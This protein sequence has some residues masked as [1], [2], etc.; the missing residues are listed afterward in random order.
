[1]TYLSDSESKGNYVP[2]RK[3]PKQSINMSLA[4]QAKLMN[5]TLKKNKS[6]VK[7]YQKTKQEKK[8]SKK[9]NTKGTIDYINDSM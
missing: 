3:S 1:M 7:K 9:P 5:Q 4:T 6:Q 8:Y 2:I